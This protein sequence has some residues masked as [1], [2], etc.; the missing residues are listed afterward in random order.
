MDFI[1][2]SPSSLAG[3]RID[4]IAC[5]GW[6]NRFFFVRARSVNFARGIIVEKKKKIGGDLKALQLILKLYTYITLFKPI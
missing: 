2:Y 5:A 1:S 6:K 4:K 3:G